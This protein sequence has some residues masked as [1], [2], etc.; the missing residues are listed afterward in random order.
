MLL[1]SAP[2]RPPP[3]TSSTHVQV[4]QHQAAGHIRANLVRLP[5]PI[6]FA[7][8][9]GFITSELADGHKRRP[10]SIPLPILALDIQS[11]CTPAQPVALESICR[12]F[13]VCHC[14]CFFFFWADTLKIVQPLALFLGSHRH[15]AHFVCSMCPLLHRHRHRLAPLGLGHHSEQ[16]GRRPHRLT[17]PHM[18]LT[19]CVLRSCGLNARLVRNT[20]AST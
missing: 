2:F 9:L 4:C 13:W 19:P 18:R 14:W 12:L 17:S 7:H 1:L 10:G 6:S 15:P 20:E 11:P 3:T 8:T 5:I 16:T